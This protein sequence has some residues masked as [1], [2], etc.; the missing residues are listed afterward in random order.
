MLP[1]V[2]IVSRLGAGGE[3]EGGIKVLVWLPV[4]P[5]FEVEGNAP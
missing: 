3:V 2:A 4:E 5:W 1:G